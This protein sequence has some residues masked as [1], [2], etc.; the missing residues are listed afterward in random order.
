MAE[1]TKKKTMKRRS[2]KEQRAKVLRDIKN[3]PIYRE[4][5]KEKPS[6]YKTTGRP[7]KYKK[8]FCTK[9][10]E[11]FD[12]PHTITKRTTRFFKGKTYDVDIEVANILPTF[13]RFSVEICNTDRTTLHD[14]C[15]KHEEFLLAYNKAKEL[16]KNMI[17][18]LGMRGLYNGQY[19]AFVAKNITDMK[20]TVV[21]EI[22]EKPSYTQEQ[23]KNLTDK[24]LDELDRI[25]AKLRGES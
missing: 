19:T 25:T 16:Q 18:D 6:Y 8:E 5:K 3:K 22:K 9:M 14:W 1:T 10:I 15:E 21:N 13:E 2:S 7:P 23:L 11:F 24:E 4:E 12:V 20:D 17:N